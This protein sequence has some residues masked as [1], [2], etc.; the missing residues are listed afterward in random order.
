MRRRAARN[1]PS[2]TGHWNVAPGGDAANANVGVVSRV[3]A[4]CAPTNPV[5]GAVESTTK[6]RV[7]GV[8]SRLLAASTARTENV[9][10]PSGRA[11]GNGDV[12]AANSPASTLH[13]NVAVASAENT[14]GGP[15]ASSVV[16]GAV[17]STVNVRVSG[18]ASWLPA[19]STARTE[20]VCSPSGSVTG[21]GAGVAS[22]LPAA[23]TARTANVCSPSGNVTGVR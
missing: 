16:S 8:A 15:P 14:N 9:C 20:K 1:A 3:S 5:S 13:S 22:R 10:W 23:S 21:N 19:A 6:V 12:H 18:V 11:T 2:S 7:A 17:V 4:G